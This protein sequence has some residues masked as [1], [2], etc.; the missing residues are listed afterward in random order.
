MSLQTDFE[1]LENNQD[2]YDDLIVSIEANKQRLNLLIAVCDYS[3]YQEKIIQQYEQELAPNIRCYRVTLARGEPSLRAAIAQL[4]E[5]EPDLQQGGEAVITVTGIEQ[6]YVIKSEGCRSEQEIFFG[7]LQWTREAL[8]Q[9]PF[10][11][12]LWVTNQIERNLSKQAPDF[13]SWRKGVFRFQC[14]QKTAISFR[15]L[16]P[17]QDI[18][19]Q[20]FPDADEDDQYFLPIQDL[21]ALIQEIEQEKGKNDP[22][23]AILYQRLGQIYQRR[24]EQGEYENYKLEQDLAIEYF[25]KAIELQKPS[26]ASI[27]FARNLNELAHLYYYQGRY[28]E[29]EPLYLQSLELTKKLLGDEHPNVATSLNN[30]AHLYYY[31][32]R[33][34]EAEPLYLQSLELTKKLLGDEHPN[35]ATSL[36]NLAGLYDSQAH[37]SE[38]EPLYLQSLELRKKLLG[39]EHPAVATSLNNLAYLY[40]SQGRYSEAEP[41]Y[42]QSLELRKKLLGDEHPDV[43][44]SLNN[45]A[46]LYQ[47]QGRYS[48]AESLYL[49]SL[50]ICKYQLGVDHPHTQ[51]IQKSLDRVKMRFFDDKLLIKL[52]K[53][54]NKIFGRLFIRK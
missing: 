47:S 43:A 23:L 27:E 18:L 34:S 20:Q 54:W 10:S 14:K 21:E 32:G 42:L 6:L 12:V 1:P 29:A 38:A 48:E 31:Q 11:I 33:Y 2:S 19:K 28:S 40:Q 53:L 3:E 39:D 46:Y 25:Q 5:Q 52:T 49:Q 22:S 4:V 24:N 8:R 30:L 45:L 51:M 17:F 7:Y 26:N 50:E 9:F 15:E 35:V 41:L 16:Q 37:Y 36:N 44:N 13:W